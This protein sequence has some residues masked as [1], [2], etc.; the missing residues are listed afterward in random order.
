MDEWGKWEDK[1]ETRAH[2]FPSKNRK[3]A[4][5]HCVCEVHLLSISSQTMYKGKNVYILLT[6]QIQH[7][8]ALIYRQVFIFVPALPSTRSRILSL[9]LSIPRA[10]ALWR[11][12]DFSRDIPVILVPK[13]DLKPISSLSSSWSIRS[14]SHGIIS[15]YTCRTPGTRVYFS[16]IISSPSVASQ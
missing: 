4:L 8:P 11:K 12:G 16:C 7:E 9:T 10:R 14:S 2:F 15:Q 3:A 5:S 1:K 6:L 13:P